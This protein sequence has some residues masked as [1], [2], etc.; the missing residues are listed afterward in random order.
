MAGMR[1]FNLATAAVA[2]TLPLV[3]AAF[4]GLITA[5]TAI[6]FVKFEGASRRAR[7]QLQ[8]M[9]MTAT[10]ARD[11]L[12]TLTGLMDRAAVTSIMQSGEA[13]LA[14]ALAGKELTKQIG[15]L[16][17]TLAD[18][19]G[20][21]PDQMFIALFEAFA[22][23]DP[24]KLKNLVF[25]MQDLQ[26]PIEVLA[27]LKRGFAQPLLDFLT[28]FTD[29]NNVTAL[30]EI[31]K[32]LERIADITRPAR[33]ALTSGVTVLISV[34]LETLATK[35][36]NAQGEIGNIFHTSLI[37]AMALA[38]GGAG[39]ALGV[40]ILVG[41]ALLLTNDLTA[42]IE[43]V[44]NNP[45]VVASILATG[46]AA[47]KL[48]GGQRGGIV[49]G[50]IIVLGIELLPGLT[51]AFNRMSQDQQFTVLGFGAGTLLG[52]AMK[53]GLFKSLAIGSI[54]QIAVDNTFSGD[55]I[56]D[57]ALVS[58]LI[59][60]G[61][62]VGGVFGGP[63]GAAAGVAVGAA[64]GEWLRDADWRGFAQEPGRKFANAFANI[65]I[66]EINKAFRSLIIWLMLKV[67]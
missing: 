40:G 1:Q 7:F 47:G 38:S 49:G 11:Q 39:R 36:E 50:I 8:L 15:P 31:V 60:A 27:A 33:E 58:S 29:E 2:A 14:V 13:M 37:V 18:L 57:K 6:N 35:L 55:S 66:D 16:A 30:E 52:I 20:V 64:L 53:Q 9:G 3:G 42:S 67:F 22:R 4:A 45:V 63:L 26:I 28:E 10:Q 48:I 46:L 56:S 41:L 32:K 19:I 34:F 23:H 62:I 43:D 21:A 61:A 59:A 51:E 65:F 5:V 17:D 12:A 54:V 44:F 25:G 24:E